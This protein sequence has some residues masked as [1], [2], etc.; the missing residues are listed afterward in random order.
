[1]QLKQKNI[2]IKTKNIILLHENTKYI[3]KTQ[4]IYALS[5][6]DMLK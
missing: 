2:K 4:V 1:M 3:R 5:L 6:V